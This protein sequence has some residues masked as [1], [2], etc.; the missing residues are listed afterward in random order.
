MLVSTMAAS[1]GEVV[2]T[3][4]VPHVRN[5]ATP[6]EAPRT[7]LLEEQWRV[8][9]PD[10][11]ETLFGVIGEVL[12]HD[13][14]DLFFLDRQLSEVQVYS[15][16]GEYIRTLSREGDGPGE[17]RRPGGIMFLPDGTLGIT[18]MM[19]GK[20]VKVDLEGT[21]AGSIFLGDPQEGRMSMLFDAFSRDDRLLVCAQRFSPGENS[22]TRTKYLSLV[23]GEGI[24][25][26]RYLE[27]KTEGRPGEFKWDEEED[28]F[29]HLGRCALGPDGRVFA[30]PV[31]DKYEIHVFAPDG[32]LE[33]VIER[34]YKQ[35]KRT[36]EDIERV[37]NSIM[38][39]TR[40][41]EVE[42]VI[43]DHDPCISRLKV[44]DEGFLWVLHS[45]SD[46][47]QRDGVFQTYDLFDPEGNYI[48]QVEV[49]CP[50]DPEE[51]GF[52]FVDDN[53]AVFVRGL[54]AAAVSMVGQRGPGEEEDDDGYAEPL[55]IVYYRV[56]PAGTVSTGREGGAGG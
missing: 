50:G 21:P 26:V 1:A 22:F 7:L 51:D 31:R 40:H 42:K 52:F 11:E 54:V 14:G 4:G 16:D 30:A 13:N 19:P 5:G 8:G 32:T 9:G 43:S 36:A 6:S 15:P 24:E 28:Y 38:I 37:D 55:E 10:D 48:R 33:R 18:Q 23:D 34:E 44:D 46:K 53:S 25:T 35:R 56:L 27:T 3:D 20:I 47:D 45:R 2:E 49:V 41:G 12:Q 17:V 29:V 39:R